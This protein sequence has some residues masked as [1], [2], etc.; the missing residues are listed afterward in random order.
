MTQN[1]DTTVLLALASDITHCS[2]A[3]TI[4]EVH[5]ALARQMQDEEDDALLPRLVVLL[6]DRPL[7]V[8]AAARDRFLAIVAGLA[9]ES[10]AARAQGMFSGEVPGLEGLRLPVNVV[11][12]HVL[13]EGDPE[14]YV[15]VVGRL[16]EDTLSRAV[17]VTGWAMG[18]TTVT[19]NKAVVRRIRAAVARAGEGV[20]GPEMLIVGCARS[21]V[22]RPKATAG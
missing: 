17:F 2:C 19:C 9:S 11:E 4:H 8:C 13:C 21:L 12:D 7:I 14:V 1:L 18:V 16:G 15:A 20:V 6:Q 10:E 22:G 5:P 3:R